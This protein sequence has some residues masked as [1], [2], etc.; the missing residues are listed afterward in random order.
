MVL[1]EWPVTRAV[2]EMLTPSTRRLATWSNSLRVQRRPLYAV[3][4]FVLTV[5]PHILQRYC[6]RRPDFVVNQP[7]P[8][9][10]MPGFPKLSHLGLEQAL[11]WMALITQV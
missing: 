10:L 11:Y 5:P 4:V 8:T 7:W 9:M 2:A 6:R 3:L 1:R